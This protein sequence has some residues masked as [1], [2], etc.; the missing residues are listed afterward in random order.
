MKRG[1]VRPRPAWVSFFVAVLALGFVRAGSAGPSRVSITLSQAARPGSTARPYYEGKSLQ[2]IVG[3]TPG[4]T[5]D[6]SARLVAKHFGKHIPGNPAILVQNMGGAGGVIASNHLYNI[7]KRDGLT[8][9]ALLRANYLEQMVGRPEVRFDFRKFSWI[10]SYNSAPMMLACRTDTGYT[11]VEKIRAAKKPPR[12]GSSGSGSIGFI[13][14]NLLEEALNFK[15]IPVLGYK[16]GRDIDLG[17]ERGEVDCRA[18][19]D[20]TIIRSPW[21][22]WLE[23]RFMSFVVQQGPKKSRILPQEVPTIYELTSPEAKR[24]L[25]LVEVMLAYTEFDRPFAA[26]PD[27]PREQLRILRESFEKMLADPGFSADAKKLLDWDSSYLNGE[28]LQRKIE[29]TLTQDAEIV[30]RVKEILQ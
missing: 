10:G 17:V 28:Q 8:I 1:T 16:S 21:P 29:R 7:A 4:G 12:F 5:T 14:G 26:P 6:I 2:M 20:I 30:K 11:S 24:V 19:S 18:S 25:D 27:T 3:T 15:L 9:G 23:K 13:F 22:E